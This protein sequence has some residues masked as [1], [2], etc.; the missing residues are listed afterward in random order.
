MTTVMVGVAV[1][2]RLWIDTTVVCCMLSREETIEFV[3]GCFRSYW[4]LLALT[5]C[6]FLLA[7]SI[8]ISPRT[9]PKIKNKLEGIRLFLNNIILLLLTGV[10]QHG[11]AR[12]SWLSNF[13]K[14]LST[15][16]LW[17]VVR[18]LSF[19]WGFLIKRNQFLSF[20]T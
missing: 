20:N 19:R 1:V 10:G 17:L 12:S 14:K 16:L 5:I 9:L 6:L 4:F 11:W 15:K 8:G 13:G 2:A 7:M 18:S 3:L